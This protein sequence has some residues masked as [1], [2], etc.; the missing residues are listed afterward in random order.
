MAE[1]IQ[2]QYGCSYTQDHQHDEDVR[3]NEDLP[4]A[5]TEHQ[6]LHLDCSSEFLPHIPSVVQKRHGEVSQESSERVT[7]HLATSITSVRT[8]DQSLATSSA[9]YH[10]HSLIQPDFNLVE[11]A[12]SMIDPNASLQLGASQQRKAYVQQHQSNDRH[13]MDGQSP[14]LSSLWDH[15]DDR[16]PI[17]NRANLR[18]QAFPEDDTTVASTKGNSMI[19]SFPDLHNPN[20]TP[21][22]TT[23]TRQNHWIPIRN[24]FIFGAAGSLVPTARVLSE[25]RRL[26]SLAGATAS[27]TG[28][29]S[30][31]VHIDFAVPSG[32]REVLD[33]I[34]NPDML[35]LWCD[36]IRDLIITSSSE[37]AKNALY[38]EGGGPSSRNR[39]YEG[40]WIDATATQ[41]VAPANTS[42]VFRA[43]RILAAMMGFPV[44]GTIT[45]FVERQRGQV[46]LTIG[47]FPGN[48][49]VCHKIKVTETGPQKIRIADEVQLGR[50]EHGDCIGRAFDWMQTFFLPSTDDYIDQV[51]SS[52]ARLRFLI[53]NGEATAP[54]A[55]DHSLISP[56]LSPSA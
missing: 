54:A 34:G 37:G 43:G 19:C 21:H 38:R 44:Y 16:I 1:E 50:K 27:V 25:E 14:T 32:F 9:E 52:M 35:Q 49:E 20:L 48:T 31:V 18:L 23:R 26:A 11:D 3:H 36:P 8:D 42:V 6:P 29:K 22:L 15:A 33:V 30:F 10:Q 53:E 17:H 47:P 45:M 28:D 13:E 7:P 56:L 24:P 41:L 2:K 12:A 46:S 39:A 5:I 51:L 4:F 40:E 55:V